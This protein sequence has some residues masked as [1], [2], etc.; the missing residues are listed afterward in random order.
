[1]GRYSAKSQFDM[2]FSAMRFYAK[3]E[4]AGRDKIPDYFEPLAPFFLRHLLWR[5]KL[6]M[7]SIIL[8][9]GGVRTGKSWTGLKL[10][11]TYLRYLHKPFNVN[12]Q[13]SFDILPF[14]KWSAEATDSGF[15][16]DEVGVNLN[17]S[18]WWTVQS[19][20][21]R[22]FTQTQGFRRNVMIL[23]LPSVAFLLKSIRFMCNYIIETRNQGHAVIR[24]IVMDHTRGKGYPTNIGSLNVSQ[25]SKEVI[26]AYESMKKV[27]ND[28]HLKS[29]IAEMEKLEGITRERN[30]PFIPP[31]LT[32]ERIAEIRAKLDENPI[33]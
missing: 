26:N 24:K 11:E 25:P 27:W 15:M 4:F 3:P 29:D 22:N 7:N 21:F 28:A 8:I 23:V 10:L 6:N 20:I 2:D 18:E 5:R 12:E 16:L 9:V 30:E 32:P 19:K 17:P 1:M 13:V 14:L 31:K 33:Y